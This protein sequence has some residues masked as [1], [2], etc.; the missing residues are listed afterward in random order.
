ML[1]LAMLSILVRF[2]AAR[3]F[4]G[5]GG[6][7]FFLSCRCSRWGWVLVALPSFLVKLMEYRHCIFKE[8]IL[9]KVNSRLLLP[10]PV[11]L[12]KGFSCVLLTT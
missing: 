11:Q 7:V 1:L 3:I 6:G 10:F 2:L 12:C 5:V 9:C 4:L 8:N